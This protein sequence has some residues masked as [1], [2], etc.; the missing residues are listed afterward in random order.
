MGYACR[1]A[2]M[3][4]CVQIMLL[5]ERLITAPIPL[6]VLVQLVEPKPATVF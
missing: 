1:Y 3:R 5:K 6:L 4:V 2:L